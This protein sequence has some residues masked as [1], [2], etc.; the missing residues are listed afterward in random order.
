MLD[1]LNAFSESLNLFSLFAP[2]FL[3]LDCFFCSI[4]QYLPGIYFPLG[5][6]LEI[7]NSLVKYQ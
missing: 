3:I 1:L 7:D 2:L 6:A 4:F 5:F